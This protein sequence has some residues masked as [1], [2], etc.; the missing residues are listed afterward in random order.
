MSLLNIFK[1]SLCHEGWEKFAD[2]I[3]P[4]CTT[5]PRSSRNEN[6]IVK[7]SMFNV[8]KMKGRV[9]LVC[10]RRHCAQEE[11]REKEGFGG[12]NSYTRSYKHIQYELCSL[13]C[14]YT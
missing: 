5:L 10:D 8:I 2:K 4:R 9:L 3:S 1:S 6:E 12:L 13:V 11:K 14:S 7:I